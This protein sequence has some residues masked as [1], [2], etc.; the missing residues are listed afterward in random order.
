VNL[1][2]LVIESAARYPLRVAVAGPEGALSYDELDRRADALAHELAARGVVRGDRVV[3]WAE[4]S[5]FVIVAMQAVLRLGAAYVPL[6]GMMPVHRAA[7]VARDCAAR[8]V[9]TTFERLPL[10]SAE[11]GPQYRCQDIAMDLADLEEVT[12]VN[13]AVGPDELAYI[14]YTSGSTGRP[15]GVCLSHRNARAFVDWAVAEL[16]AGPDDRFANHAPFTFD[17]S[18]LDIYAPFAA[19]GSVHLI[20]KEMAYAPSQLV[21]FLRRAEITVWYSVPSALILMMR[22]GGLLDEPAPRSL[23]ALLFA[24][25]PF[26]IAH[27]RRL[28]SW[29]PARLLNLYGPTETN[30]CTFR[31]V[32]ADDLLRERPV[33]IGAVSCGDIAWAVRGDGLIAR[34]GDEGEL[35]VEGPTV[36]LGYWGG[37]PV[38]GPYRTGD[39][40]RVLDDGS[41]DYV[42]RRDHMVKVRGHRVEL[43]EIEAVLDAHPEVEDAA[44][45]V[46]GEG[47]GSRLVA[48]IIPS[49]GAEPGVLSIKRHCGQRLPPYMIPD[50]IRFTAELPR[51]GNGKVDRALLTQSL[52]ERLH[53]A[54]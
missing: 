18:V 5:P 32:T 46:T 24:G 10:I 17:L 19:G 38:T 49:P 22:D 44:V 7:M 4:K 54:Q 37:E 23:R 26:P 43:G 27:V 20:P 30:V 35:L 6:D 14:L 8:V 21:E 3:I 13:T 11:L 39:I 50:E 33:P 34:P 45:V 36:M 52:A 29:T 42:G 48:V 9:C 31:A 15:K 53:Q 47:M 40:V 2:Q 25:E 41:F 1:H 16:A 51:T 28:A 12:P